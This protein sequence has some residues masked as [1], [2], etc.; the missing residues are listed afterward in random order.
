MF[1][2]NQGVLSELR[3][4]RDGM[5]WVKGSPQEYA[6]AA[7]MAV[8]RGRRGLTEVAVKDIRVSA[9]VLAFV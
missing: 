4:A 6:T 8:L 9:A 2:G 5:A 7:A 1:V 3:R